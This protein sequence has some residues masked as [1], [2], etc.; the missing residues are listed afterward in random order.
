M[1]SGTEIQNYFT[2]AESLLWLENITKSPISNS[3][4]LANSTY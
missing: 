2:L 1:F 4:L 3:L